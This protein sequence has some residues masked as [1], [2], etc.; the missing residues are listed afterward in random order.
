MKRVALAKAFYIA[1]SCLLATVG[2]AM[3]IFCR[4]G[5]ELCC[6]IVG[7]VFLLTGF[8]KL[9]SYFAEDLYSLVFQFDL[10][11][12]ITA[13]MTGAAMIFRR[14][15]ISDFLPFV[16]GV[17]VLID[18]GFRLQAAIDARRFGMWE[19]RIMA[20]AAAICSVCG[21][22][23]M[24]FFPG[25]DSTAVSFAGS[26]LLA[27]AATNLFSVLCAVKIPKK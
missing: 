11:L 2:I 21:L 20:S 14:D 8:V 27:D 19:W 4:A 26:A 1:S 17:F 24:L 13:C 10:A 3:I 18:G 5:P 16:T 25:L 15:C 9:F 23:L 22:M 6:T 7:A 12:G